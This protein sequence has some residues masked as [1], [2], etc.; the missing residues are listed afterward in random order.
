MKALGLALVAVVAAVSI[1]LSDAHAKRMGGG[2]SVGKQSPGVTQRQATP[3][4]QNAGPSQNTA[5]NQAAAP[6]AP[7]PQAGAAGARPGQPAAA[8]APAG[9]RW[10]GP[11]AGIAAGLGLAALAH[12]L[13]FGEAFGSIMLMLLLAGVAVVVVRMLLARRAASAPRP[14]YAGGYAYTGLG[15]EASVPN[16]TPSGA[17]SARGAQAIDEVRS[18]T[19]PVTGWR[20]PEG[21][22]AEAFVRSAKVNF[23]RLQAAFDA[24]NVND[25]R[26]FTSPEMFAELKMEISERNGAANQTDVVTLE[27]EMVGVE[28][29]P[30]EHLASVRF[31]GLLRESPNPAAEP[32]DEVWNFSKPADG[33]GG[34]VLAG[35]QQL[36]APITH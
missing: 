22:D 35:I 28:S 17:T 33:S 5:P 19:E 21:F 1:G 9:N 34:W 3:P 24:G 13:G 4:A 20:A 27:A 26:E 29:G 10:L 12:H 14:A 23:V 7:A 36:S 11:I 25:L 30:I 8:P 15:Q 32:F 6:A 16:Y 31:T 18:S 2:G